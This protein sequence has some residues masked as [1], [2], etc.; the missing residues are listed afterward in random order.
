MT[1]DD[2][3]LFSGSLSSAYG[4]VRYGGVSYKTPVSNFFGAQGP[5][6]VPGSTG[7]AGPTGPTGPTGAAA[8]IAVGTVTA[9]AAG[10][11]P[12]IVNVGTSGA[13]TFNF[14]IP[15]GATGPG[16]AAATISVGT[17]TG[18]AAGSAPTIV[19]T[20]TSSAAVF[21]FGIPAG[22]NGSGVPVGGSTGQVLAKTSAADYAVG[23]TT[24]STGS[25]TVSVISTNTTAVSGTTYVMTASLTLTLPT[26][27]AAGANVGF[28]NR[29][30][31]TTCVIGRAA[32]NIMGLAQDMTL[33]TINAFGRLVF[34]DATRGWVFA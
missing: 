26:S 13:A 29:S 16:G 22:A 21:N 25:P 19:N 31:V 7:P 11:T 10:A 34:A 18:L 15:A 8:T 2:L 24:P 4:L 30:G 3:P 33:D 17:V 9:L 23:W 28:V 27:P 5:Q 1:I 32:Q 6:G 20:G 12:T 14:G